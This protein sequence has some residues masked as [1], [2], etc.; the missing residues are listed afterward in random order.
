MRTL[1]SLL[2]FVLT[3]LAATAQTPD[4]PGSIEG[5]IATN[6]QPAAF[7]NI[8]LKGTRTGTTTDDAGTFR[9]GGV[10]AGTYTLQA[11]GVGFETLRE[12]ISVVA[13]QTLQLNLSILPSVKQLQT[14]EITGRKET[15]YTNDQSF[16]GSKTATPLRDLPQ[17]VA[18]VTKEILQDQA[19]FRLNDA[20]KNFSGVN[21]FSFYNDLTI[22]GHRVSGGD[23]YASLVNGL[24]ANSS[25]WKQNLTPHLERVEVIKGPASAL[26]GNTSPGGTINR[27]TKKPLDESRQSL[28][29]STGSFNTTR[30]LADFT[31]PMNEEKTLLYRLNV[32]YENAMSFRDVQFDKNIIV[33]PSV[34]FLPTQNTRLNFDLVYQN[35]TG[36]LDRG[37]AVLSSGD[38]FSVPISRSINRAN[39][40]LN[41]ETYNLTFSLNHRFSNRVSF[42][43]SYM[44]TG[45]EEDLLEHRGANTYAKDATGANINTL[46]EMQVFI[47]KRRWFDDNISNYFNIDL[48]TGPVAHRLVVGYD[49][50]QQRLAPGGSQLLARGYR[51]AANTGAINTFVPANSRNYL[52]DSRGNPVP[53]VPHFDLSDPN[54]N[55]LADMS[56]YFY[57]RQDF[58]PTYYFTQGVYVQN[59]I[60]I[61]KL[62]AL[63][64]L[65]QDWFTEYANYRTATEKAVTQTALLPRLGLTYGLT[66]TVNLY[67][68]YTQGYQPQ[69]ASQLANPTAGGPFDPLTSNL[70]EAGAKTDWLGNRLTIN[71]AIYRLTVN[72]ALYNAALAAQPDLLV[73][74]GQEVAQGVELD[75]VGQLAQ[76][77][78]IQASYAFNDATITQ[79]KNEADIGRQKPNAPRHQ[80]SFW[81]K[82]VV[83]RGPLAGLGFGLGSNFVSERFGSIV[84]AGAQPV[85]LP[86]YQLWNAALYYR[87]GKFQVQMNLNNLTNR[88]H[89]VGGYDILRLFPGA[90]RHYLATVAYTF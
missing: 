73:Q 64:G 60:S 83:G 59:Q 7:V 38:L 55:F 36:R 77:W 67:A 25:F 4:A 3:A 5:R 51:N 52:L 15:T 61:G 39:D 46:V 26:F 24:R 85:V 1:Y 12:T 31:G 69:T 48:N 19:V 17:S 80:G 28:S 57:T 82:Y 81:T 9:L 58:P 89:W 62:K 66:P 8:S 43:S 47:R 71:A 21:Q 29:F 88:T 49:Y 68:T 23:N 20:V 86:T 18:Y 42:N 27:V 11:S 2:F 74:I 6:G 40:Y 33:A 76:N 13:G 54:G 32:G 44:K 87:T 90:P 63:L 14:V 56:K 65:R 45:Y 35:S 30:A 70:L 22:R 84:A 37:Q 53:N 78:S 34:S 75:V 79:S 10:A 41:E 16:I 50:A 72:G